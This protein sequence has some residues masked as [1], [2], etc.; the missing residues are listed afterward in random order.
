MRLILTADVP[1]LGTIGDLVSV[2]AGYGRNFLLPRKMA[3][4]ANESNERQLQHQKRVLAARREKILA[5]KKGVAKKIEALALTLTKQAGEDKR[6]FGSVTS[7]ELVQ[8]L[9]EK[10][11]E[12]SK[13]DVI[14]P[15]E[16][17]ELGTFAAK[18][19]LHSDVTADLKFTIEAAT[20]S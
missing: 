10:S 11:I 16:A 20:E 1:S 8:L 6:I 3:V 5:E 18:V 19:K 2:K 13:R 14:V 15:E 12:V 9:G 17:K 7:A 4:P